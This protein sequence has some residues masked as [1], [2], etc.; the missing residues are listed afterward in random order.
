MNLA[1]YHSGLC[2]GLN[3]K[4]P[5]GKRR[6]DIDGLGEWGISS[7][8]STLKDAADYF[9]NSA[10]FHPISLIMLFSFSVSNA[11]ISYQAAKATIPG[12]SQTVDATTST[13]MRTADGTGATAA[14]VRPLISSV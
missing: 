13:T 1:F 14:N 4:Q 6:D 10:V 8:T 3:C 9:I 5:C 12:T 11:T 2:Q 7:C